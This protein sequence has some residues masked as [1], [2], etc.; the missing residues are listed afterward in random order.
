V[1][2]LLTPEEAA[3]ILKL[4]VETVREYIRKKLIPAYK[5]GKGYRIRKDDIE[6]F[7]ES[8]RT[9]KDE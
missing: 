2:E 5:V 1:E 8:R 7:L 6:K 9:D 3:A 4:N